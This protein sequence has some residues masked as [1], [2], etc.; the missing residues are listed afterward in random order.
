M[1]PLYHVERRDPTSALAL[2]FP[3]PEYEEEFQ[4]CKRYL[5]DALEL[6]GDATVSLTPKAL[7][8]RYTELRRRRIVID[9][10]RRY[11]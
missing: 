3:T 1:N 5:P 8:E 6:P 2:T 4:E 10:P 11:Y 9:T 7:G